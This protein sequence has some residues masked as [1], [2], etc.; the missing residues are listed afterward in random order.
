L[1]SRYSAAGFVEPQ[2][3][4]AIAKDFCMSLSCYEQRMG[5]RWCRRKPSRLEMRLAG[6]S[7]LVWEQHSPEIPRTSA[8][9]CYTI[10]GK[11]DLPCGRENG[12]RPSLDAEAV[13]S[14][15]SVDFLCRINHHET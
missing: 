3:H 11:V 8:E 13:V 7:D 2:Q 15:S 9:N 14:G 6:H 5:N 10:W 12:A 1:H 4:A